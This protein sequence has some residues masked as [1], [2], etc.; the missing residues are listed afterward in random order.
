MG[1]AHRVVGKLLSAPSDTWSDSLRQDALTRQVFDAAPAGMA[2]LDGAACISLVNLAWQQFGRDNGGQPTAVGTDYLAVCDAAAATDPAVVDIAHGLRAVLVGTLD[3]YRSEY[4]C[5]SPEGERWFEVTVR[6]VPVDGRIGVVVAHEDVTDRRR[7][8]DHGRTRALL[9]DEVDAAVVAT[10]LAGVVTSWS[11]GAHRLYGW[12]AQDA[13]GRPVWELVTGLDVRD[14]ARRFV[15]QLGAT[16][17]WEGS[18]AATRANGTTV[19]VRVRNVVV[20]DSEG[21]PTGMISIAVDV[22]E[23]LAL[24]VQLQAI[25]DSIGEGLCTLDRDGRISY[26]NP[27]GRR[28]L[29]ASPTEVLGGSFRHWI[30]AVD[31]AQPWDDTAVGSTARPVRCMLVRRD[32]SEL[33]IEYVA[34]PLRS[35][36]VAPATGWV[37]VFRDLS[38]RRARE[39]ALALQGDD[40]VWLGRI[41]DALDHDG[42]E[43][44]AQPIVDLL[45]GATVQ[46]E[47]LL[48]MHDPDDP[49]QVIRPGRFLPVAE[50]LGMAPAIDGWVLAR[51]LELAAQGHPVEINLS[52]R[53]IEAEET[54]HLIEQLLVDTGA[55]PANIVFELTETALLDNDVTARY[56]ADRIHE[57]GC[58]LAL[59][60]F[61]TGFGGFTYLK[62][63]PLDYLKIDIEFV[64]DAVTDAASRHVIEA[65]VSLAASF[66]LRTVAEGVENEATL[67]LLRQMGV[68]FAQGYLLGRPTPTHA[69]FPSPARTEPR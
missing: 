60:D 33:P 20:A 35:A 59:D 17:T 36:A 24:G 3:A 41:R 53:S 66:D 42:F 54:P 38:A 29:R 68:D 40:Q 10:D 56:F 46:H 2:V 9:V 34:T 58:G 50:R 39:D 30:H 45:T 62:Q 14:E 44:H 13:V 52:A 64:R 19:S 55:D 65:V 67:D 4:P 63:F 51:G 16:E 21:R 18:F 6:P 69:T 61:G 15:E 37:V 43:L 27:A 8:T 22:T 7:K 25:T 47:L 28:M 49:R 11:R 5:H 1:T 26:V 32:G 48:R 57:L 31:G 12:S 23:Q